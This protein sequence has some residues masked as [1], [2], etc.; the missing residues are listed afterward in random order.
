MC[1]TVQFGSYQCACRPS[2]T[3]GTRV[4]MVCSK[5]STNPLFATAFAE[6]EFF[7]YRSVLFLSPRLSATKRDCQPSIPK[8]VWFRASVNPADRNS[9]R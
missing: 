2:H 3:K 6:N 7:S 1:I 8:P 4:T 5:L 9:S